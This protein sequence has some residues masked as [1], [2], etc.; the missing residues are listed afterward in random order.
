LANV[1]GGAAVRGD[2][3]MP[4]AISSISAKSSGSTSASLVSACAEA[5]RFGKISNT[6][7]FRLRSS[8]RLQRAS[9]LLPTSQDSKST[10]TSGMSMPLTVARG[11]KSL[12]GSRGR[13]KTNKQTQLTFFC[14]FVSRWRWQLGNRIRFEN[15]RIGGKENSAHFISAPSRF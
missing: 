2:L 14:L 5:D 13:K 3:P 7:R 15:W 1:L 8:G 9:P 11:Q 6:M 4:L 10:F 12:A